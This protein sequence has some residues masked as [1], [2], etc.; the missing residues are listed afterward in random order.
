VVV[1]ACSMVAAAGGKRLLPGVE[2]GGCL[3]QQ[4]VD[5]PSLLPGL[6]RAGC[7]PGPVAQ[8]SLSA[9]GVL[10]LGSRYHC[11]VDGPR[12]N[13]EQQHVLDYL[14]RLRASSSSAYDAK[15]TIS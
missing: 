5:E 15:V 3:G 1:R 12:V 7:A 9:S 10:I 13:A 11:V 4:R 6:Q 2:N 8:P 14:I